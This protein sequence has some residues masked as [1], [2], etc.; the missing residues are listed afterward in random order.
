MGHVPRKALAPLE[1]DR[2]PDQDRLFRCRQI[3]QAETTLVITV[4]REPAE[5]QTPLE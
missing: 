5:R 1:P 3:E 2:L 4:L